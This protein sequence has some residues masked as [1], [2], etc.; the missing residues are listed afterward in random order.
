MELSRS[1]EEGGQKIV[2]PKSKQDEALRQV[3]GGSK[4]DH[5]SFLFNSG[6]GIKTSFAGPFVTLDH[7]LDTNEENAGPKKALTSEFAASIN[8][9]KNLVG[10]G[11]FAL[12][13]AFS[14]ASVVVGIVMMAFV[15]ALCAGAFILIARNC[16]ALG[17]ATYRDMGLKAMGPRL[18]SL[19]DMCI[20]VNGMLG[21]LAYVILVCDFFEESIPALFGMHFERY[22]LV[23]MDTLA[24]ILPLS[25][26]KDLSPLRI[27]SMIALAIIGYIFL[28]VVIDWIRDFESGI[29]NIQGG[30][31]RVKLGIFFAAS[32]F[33][34]AFSAHYNAPTFYRELGEDLAAHSRV[35]RN[36][37]T[38]AFVMYACFALAGYAKWGDAV[39]GNMLKN[40]G[41]DGNGGNAIAL[42][43]F[44]MSFSITLSFPL[45]FNSCRLA[46]YGLFPAI[47]R[48]RNGNPQTVHFAVTTVLVL[49]ICSAACF[50]KDVQ[51][52]VGM[53]GALLGQ[54][55]C[56][57]IPG[58]V[59]L[60]TT[61][62]SDATLVGLQR[63]EVGS[64][65]RYLMA[66]AILLM[67]WGFLCQV[68][69]SLVTLEIVS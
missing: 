49:M 34:G 45:V 69:G 43:L 40:Y 10:S 67:V 31:F 53:T 56:F 5:P 21:P 61:Y 63:R 1:F 8:L 26:I 32:I 42:A 44:G 4:H 59:Y 36:S 62:D 18:A 68:V 14:R 46:F 60:K 11:I 39:Q 55:I 23:A 25:Y 6:S 52:V 37:Y 28:Y 27:P 51:L 58:M 47:A 54:M 50:V 64:T 12:P 29:P 7:A 41:Q 13:M 16:K 15:G 24:L 17:V 33:T 48:A 3:S 66:F 35:V 22:Q 9:T 65:S 20:M 19:I 38:A 30:A 57:I 2:D